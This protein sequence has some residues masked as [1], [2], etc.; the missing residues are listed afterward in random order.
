MSGTLRVNRC[1]F[2]LVEL[3]A[4]IVVLAILAG[5]AVP[6]YFD[7][8]QRARATAVAATFKSLA[9]AGYAYQR[10]FGV[11]PSPNVQLVGAMPPG[12]SPYVD[13]SSFVN[14]K[15][16]GATWYWN[17]YGIIGRNYC[18]IVLGG[19]TLPVADFTLI[20]QMIDDGNLTTGAGSWWPGGT[21][22]YNYTFTGQ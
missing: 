7:Y 16:Y 20:D 3:I 9:T 19:V 6:R 17:G 22:W 10:D 1:G 11:L 13:T 2:T 5:V 18:Q 4:V 15:P 8:S 12:L 14:Q 21:F